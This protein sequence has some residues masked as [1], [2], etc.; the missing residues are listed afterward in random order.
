MTQEFAWFRN[1]FLFWPINLVKPINMHVAHVT[2]VI[3]IMQPGQLIAISMYVQEIP[4]GDGSNTAS[5]YQAFV[6]ERNPLTG[7]LE[8]ILGWVSREDYCM[9]HGLPPDWTG[10]DSS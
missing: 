8:K 6:R 10:I 2:G 3:K 7:K 1:E 5:G 4:I 9:Y